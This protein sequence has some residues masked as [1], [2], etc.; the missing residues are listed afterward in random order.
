MVKFNEIK[1]LFLWSES[2]RVL[3]AVLFCLGFSSVLLSVASKNDCACIVSTYNKI[4]RLWDNKE[5][6]EFHD[7]Q[8]QL[9]LQQQCSKTTNTSQNYNAYPM[10]NFHGHPSNSASTFQQLGMNAYPTHLPHIMKEMRDSS[11][12]SGG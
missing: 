7:K 9:L 1:E 5:Q 8:Q 10:N 11:S 12:C 3:W 6:K 4:S 2:T